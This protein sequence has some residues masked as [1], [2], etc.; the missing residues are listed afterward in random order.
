MHDTTTILKSF[1]TNYP[2]TVLEIRANSSIFSEVKTCEV[3][4]TKKTDRKTT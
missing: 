1:S 3:K 4:T 2:D